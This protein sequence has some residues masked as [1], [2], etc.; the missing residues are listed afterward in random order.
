[1]LTD[2]LLENSWYLILKITEH[3]FDL[4][5]T[6]IKCDF[7]EHAKT[8]LAKLD[9]LSRKKVES[10]VQ[11][12]VVVCSGKIQSLICWLGISGVSNIILYVFYISITCFVYVCVCVFVFVY[13]SH[14]KTDRF[15]QKCF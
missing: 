7:G 12:S 8:L 10:V 9:G 13:N 6:K 14:N 11:D 5:F 1:M 2:F 4:S 3:Y 15:S